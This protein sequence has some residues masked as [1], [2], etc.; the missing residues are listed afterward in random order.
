[1]TDFLAKFDTWMNATDV[2]VQNTP[3]LKAGKVDFAAMTAT[4]AKEMIFDLC[5]AYG[6]DTGILNS[7]KGYVSAPAPADNGTETYVKEFAAAARD[8]WY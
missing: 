5:F 8:E 1:M 4:A 2:S 3:Y 7:Y 6:S